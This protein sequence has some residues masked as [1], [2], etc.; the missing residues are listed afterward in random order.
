MLVED[1]EAVRAF[2]A[3]ALEKKGYEVVQAN[4]GIEGLKVFNEQA[5]SVDLIISDII[6]PE[7]G[8]FELIEK[9]QETNP[10]IRV[11]FISGYAEEQFADKFDTYSG[12]ITFL[13]KP[14]TLQELIDKVRDMLN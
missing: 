4:S 10:D 9:I 1:E 8:G 3:R 6:M 12:N 11:I 7:L 13:P 2:S 14:Y 5:D